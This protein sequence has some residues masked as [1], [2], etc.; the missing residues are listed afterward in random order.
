M[1][2][3]GN[4]NPQTPVAPLEA[5]G[6]CWNRR[7][8]AQMAVRT[9][10]LAVLSTNLR[11]L[12]AR[13]P[14]GLT[15]E[16]KA[17]KSDGNDWPA[18]LGPTGDGKSTETGLLDKWPKEGPKLLW[19]LATGTGYGIGSVS[20]GCF[21][22]FDKVEGKAR[23]LVVDAATGVEKW[24]FSYVSSYVDLYGYDDGPRCSAVIDGDRVYLY[25]VEGMVH[26]LSKRDGKVLWKVDTIEE[27][28]VIQN[29]FGVGSTPVV[30]DDLLIVMVGGSPPESA[31]VAPGQLDLVEP[32][33]TAVVAFDKKTGKERYR[34]GNDLAS[35][36][37]MKIVRADGKSRDRD[38]G[39]AFCRGGLV[40][41]DP[42]NGKLDFQ[43]PFRDSGLE[44]V[45]ASMPV[46]V[47]DEVFLSET[48]G[49]GSVLLKLATPKPTVV[50]QDKPFSRVKAMQTHWNTAIEHN[51]FLYGSSGR[52]KPNA[53]LRCIEWATGKVRWTIPRLTRA[54][55]TYADEKFY[56]MCEDGRLLLIAAD[57]D[58]YTLLSEFDFSA[59]AIDPAAARPSPMLGDPCWAAP[60]LSHGRLYVRGAA[61]RDR[62][63]VLC[64]DVK[65]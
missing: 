30:Y 27:Y 26:C 25:G 23:L 20:D 33:G 13:E 19:H 43:F 29:F 62:G 48:Y 49:P 3:T 53:E 28:G 14:S 16:T 54:S 12:L 55:L 39:L 36:A 56:A 64:L 58:K 15:E 31:R 46:V 11:Q 61:G 52:H 10:G 7:Y 60:V 21:Y 32:N 4:K 59:K 65:G 37:S 44:S 24:S 34:V 38:W 8:F 50:W 35:Y 5:V 51:G 6:S 2:Q 22:H 63:R 41:F 40:A 47:G 17:E 42:A 1:H 45:N 57:P 18:F 9:I